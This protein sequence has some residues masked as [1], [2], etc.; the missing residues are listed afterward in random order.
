MYKIQ[1]E[2]FEGP[3][4]LLLQLIESE[5][6]DITKVALAQVADQY[7]QYMNATE[8]IS[9]EELADFLVVAARL[10]YVKSRALLPILEAEEEALEDDLEKQLRLYKE[11]V[12][13]SAE[14]ERIIQRKHFK[15]SRDKFYL[16]IKPIFNP[17]KGLTKELMTTIYQDVLKGIQPLM[18]L[19]EK[20]LE[21]TI[22]LEEKVLQLRE[23]IEQQKQLHFSDILKSS[24]NRIDVVVSF[25]A[26]LELLKSREVE[27]KQVRLF[28]DMIISKV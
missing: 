2:P 20:T 28:E 1:L 19:P 18:T 4:D 27:V 22:S 16:D 7:L 26:L 11:F 14:V 3:L 8:T 13:A 15:Y 6:L 25:M 21:R 5:D 9:P 17:P 24:S 10:L 23:L 12:K